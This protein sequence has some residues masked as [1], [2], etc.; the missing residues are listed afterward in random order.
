MTID[1]TELS[2]QRAQALFDLLSHHETYF[3][4]TRFNLPDGIDEYGP[5]FDPKESGP[6]TS[7][8]LQTLIYRFVLTLPG[9]R[10]V[11]SKFWQNIQQLMKKLAAANLSESYDH[12][13]LGL[14]RSLATGSAALLEYPARGCFGGLKE[15]LSNANRTDYDYNDPDDI[16]QAWSDF[17][18]EVVYSDMI[19]ELFEVVAV[20]E[21]L[22]EH[23]PMVQ[24]A[25][26]YILV[27]LVVMNLTDYFALTSASLASVL[28]YV[29][30]KAPD[31][32]YAQNLVSSILRLLPWGVLRQSLRI[33]NAASMINAVTRLFLTKLSLTS[34]TNWVGLSNNPDDG[35]NLLQQ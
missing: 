32:S 5:P 9:L 17:L 18:Q 25:H 2:P 33:G 30:V 21:N 14:R 10:D 6:S 35:M 8:I 3:E 11:S 4:C 23:K 34:F 7:P 15:D 28:H 1:P 13:G 12:G 20:T 24:A 19:D 27:K 26:E 31:A 16:T 22:S 29:F